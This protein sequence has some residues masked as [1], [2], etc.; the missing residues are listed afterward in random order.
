[1]LTGFNTKA[2]VTVEEKE[3]KRAKNIKIK[4]KFEINNKGLFEILYPLRFDADP[5]IIL[6]YDMIL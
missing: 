5:E 4:D 1:M 3:L 6:K 2:R